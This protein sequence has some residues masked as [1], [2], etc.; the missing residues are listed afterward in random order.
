MTVR[1]LAT[2]YSSDGSKPTISVVDSTGVVCEFNAQYGDFIKDEL[3]DREISEYRIAAG[4]LQRTIVVAR[5]E[6]S[7]DSEGGD[8]DVRETSTDNGN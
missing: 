1:D 5:L 2:K 4:L 7:T 8:E 6:E 3:M